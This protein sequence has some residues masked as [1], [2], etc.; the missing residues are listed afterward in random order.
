MMRTRWSRTAK[1][2]GEVTRL[3]LTVARVLGE[4]ES[5]IVEHLGGEIEGHATL[6]EVLSGFPRI[7]L[8]LNDRTIVG[9]T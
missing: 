2:K 8:E 1:P 5:G 6:R 3:G 9:N 4:D 7:P